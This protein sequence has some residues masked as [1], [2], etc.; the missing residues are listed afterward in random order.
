MSVIEHPNSWFPEFN[1]ESG[2]GKYNM[3]A[4][5]IIS[6][7]KCCNNCDYFAESE[8][9]FPEG[10]CMKNVAN[11]LCGQYIEN[12]STFYCS[13]YRFINSLGSYNE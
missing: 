1:I 12:V 6:K 11:T 8:L 10:L 9:E 7:K 3:V 5:M 13:Y 4:K 2:N